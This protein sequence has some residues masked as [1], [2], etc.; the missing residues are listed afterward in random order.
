MLCQ[1]VDATDKKCHVDFGYEDVP[2]DEKSRRVKQ[3]FD[4]VAD[5]YDV[6]N[7]VISCGLHRLWKRFTVSL[8]QLKPGNRVLDLASGTGDLAARMWSA[9][10]HNGELVVADINPAMLSNGR[11]R[12]ID[13]GIGSNVRY[14]LAD[15]ESLPFPD[16]FFD[17]ITIGFGLRNVTAKQNALRSMYHCLKPG[18]RLL[19]LEF[20]K[21]AVPGLS[22]LYD[23]YSFSVL[24]KMG[25]AIAGD[26]D[27]YRYLA[28]SIRR[29]PDQETLKCMMQE[30]GF[31]SCQFY[32]LA[33]GIVAVHRGYRF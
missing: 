7:D 26:E 8:C 21:P 2:Y 17:V 4:S 32:N 12:L 14:V 24:P 19:V 30:A 13:K 28:E 22:R 3:V 6:M 23:L 15:A 9:I 31:E 16:R 29:H 27:S 20:S 10:G 18:G 11:D 33:G 1:M 5:R 25:R